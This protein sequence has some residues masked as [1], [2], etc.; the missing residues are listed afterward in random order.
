MYDI[1][2]KRKWYFLISSCLIVPGI[3]AMVISTLTVGTP[4]RLSIDFTG[5]TF[6]ELAF[7]Q[8]VQPAEVRAVFVAAG[9]SST[10]VQT[11]NE[12]R[13]AIVRTEALEPEAKERIKATLAQQFGA[14]K[15]VY[16]DTLGAQVGQE[17]TVSALVAVAV[18]SLAIIGYI[19]LAFRKVPNPVRY[20]ACAIFS[21]VHDVLVVL[22]LFSILG[23]LLGWE[24]D[25]LFLTAVLTVIGFSVQ[26]TI[27]VFDRIREN[28][29]RHRGEPFEDIVNHSLLQ[30]IHR[31]L[32]TQTNAMFV[33][34]ALLFFG[35]AT[36]QQF[37]LAMLVGLLSGT[38]SSL[39]NAVPL[40]VVWEKGEIPALL[41]RLFRRGQPAAA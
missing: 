17:V 35:G 39:F 4:V 6:M 18:A 24:V 26:D 2:G 38:Y 7:E 29:P 8:P 32:V 36:I 5:G 40:L 34:V 21:M 23:L 12:G 19:V 14:V 13:Q 11:T 22:G 1:V 27:V 16:S 20:G 31:S 10:S 41:R 33:M 37:I 25:A 9:Y 30:T 28:I 15:E 3:I